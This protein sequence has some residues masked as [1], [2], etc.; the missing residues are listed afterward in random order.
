MV[1]PIVFLIDLLFKTKSR[2][3][4]DNHYASFYFDGL[5]KNFGNN[6]YGTCN[7]VAIGM[8]L[9][10]YDTYWDEGFIPEKYDVKTNFAISQLN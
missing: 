5:N 4:L 6:T 8:I 9:S 2:F 1:S 10:F 3:F 7:Y